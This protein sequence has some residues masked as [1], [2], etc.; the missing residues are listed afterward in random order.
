[1]SVSGL[2]TDDSDCQTRR[3]RILTR[4]YAHTNHPGFHTHQTLIDQVEY[5]I[6]CAVQ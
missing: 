2:F 5:D 1:M 3:A 4:H 6:I